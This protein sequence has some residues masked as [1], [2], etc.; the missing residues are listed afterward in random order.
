MKTKWEEEF[1][2]HQMIIWFSAIIVVLTLFII[3]ILTVE[4][5]KQTDMQKT[6]HAQQAQ[7]DALTVQISNT[8]LLKEFL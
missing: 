5:A 6:I 1:H 4:K 3:G 7:I 2:K 8:K